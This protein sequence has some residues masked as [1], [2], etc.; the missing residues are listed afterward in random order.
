[1]RTVESGNQ[2]L[3]HY[4]GKLEDGTV[5]D[6]SA[7]REPLAFQVGSGQ[8]ISGFEKGVIG[9]G[10]GEKKTISILPEDGYGERNDNYIQEVDKKIFDG[11]EE[12]NKGQEVS[13]QNDTGNIFRGIVDEIKDEKVVIDF[14]HPLAGKTLIFDLELVTI[15]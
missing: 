7:G 3:I 5:F 15:S 10:E 14:N 11:S 1:M 13:L 6:S 4:T 9:M 8:V 12:L 2:V